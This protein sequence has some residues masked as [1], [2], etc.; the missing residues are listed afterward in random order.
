M[1]NGEI[2]STR[3]TGAPVAIAC[4]AIGS[5]ESA[6]REFRVRRT[7]GGWPTL[8][9]ALAVL[10]ACDGTSSAPGPTSVTAIMSPTATAEP[11]SNATSV[12]NSVATTGAT[13]PSPTP[14]QPT[15][16]TAA[17]SSTTP[18]LTAPAGPSR[19]IAVG[20]RSFD[21]YLTGD[22]CGVVPAATY[23]PATQKIEEVSGND[24]YISDGE[25]VRVY[26]FNGGGSIGLLTFHW[27]A[28]SYQA[29][30]NEPGGLR[31]EV[32][33]TFS[34]GRLANSKVVEVYTSGN[35]TCTLTYSQ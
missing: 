35:G 20:E 16:T 24:G 30:L 34:D 12:G 8:L 1:R 22:T 23:L 18:T 5:L 2:L 25:Q 10:S 27:P 21:Y 31:V 33:H 28:L 9:V 13:A 29:P 3:E 26:G 7:G 17:H 19:S 14:Q 4:Q 11:N 6:R 15:A 32:T